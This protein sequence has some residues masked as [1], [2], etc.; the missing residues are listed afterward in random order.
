M[1]IFL[2][3]SAGRR[4]RA[5]LFVITFLFIGGAAAPPYQAHA[6]ET[7][8]QTQTVLKRYVT[9]GAVPTQTNYWELIDTIFW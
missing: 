4:C 8:P 6:Q 3:Q 1:K 7:V 9:T 5:A 2:P